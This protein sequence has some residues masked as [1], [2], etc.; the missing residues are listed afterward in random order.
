[1]R[2]PHKMTVDPVDDLIW[3]GDVG[4][5]EREE[6][7]ILAPGANFQWPAMEGLAVG[8]AEKPAVPLGAWTDPVADVERSE[9]RSI[10]GGFVY[11][12]N[13]LPELWG[14]YIF[15]DFASGNLWALPYD[16]QA[17]TVTVGA[18]ELLFQS[19]FRD[20]AQN[21]LTS[22]GADA[23]GELYLLL[24][25]TES[26]IRRLARTPGAANV[27]ARL[28][29]TGAF[30]ET[31]GLVPAPALFPYDVASPLYSDGADKRRWF[32]LPAGD[33]V[34]FSEVGPLGFPDGSVF[35]KH[36]EIALDE[37]EPSRKTRLETRFLVSGAGGQH[38]GVTYRWNDAG[39]DADLVLA[40]QQARLAV[41]REDGSVREQSY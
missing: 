30:T 28:S 33:G 20:Y 24:F 36:F 5:G 25:G 18:R 10:I 34:R 31:T 27:P 7:D 15:G 9:A 14:K 29:E 6:I 37:R 40:S 11:R 13:A 32:A 12:G 16:N 8:F 35:V 2:S 19:E 22:F 3:I 41:T 39:T 26:K 21:G 17:G 1:L 38:Y 4:Q 23:D